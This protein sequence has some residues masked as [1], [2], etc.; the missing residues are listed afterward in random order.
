MLAIT[1]K[2]KRTEVQDNPVFTYLVR[3]IG[4]TL[5]VYRFDTDENQLDTAAGLFNQFKNDKS[6]FIT[7]DPRCKI[8][9]INKFVPDQHWSV[10]R[11]WTPQ[12]RIDLG[13]INEEEKIT[14]DAFSDF[15][16]EIANSILKF[17][18]PL[19]ELGVKKNF[20]SNYKSI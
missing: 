8:Q 4:E 12:E 3:E 16:G 20:K 2:N 15:I 17:Q 14:L 18:N 1:K 19:K 10:D 13:I 5:D 7:S 11:W 9:P 6:H